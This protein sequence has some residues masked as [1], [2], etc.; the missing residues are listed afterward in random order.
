M[1][2]GGL[3]VAIRA[4]R[5][6]NTP[7]PQAHWGEAVQVST[8]RPMLLSQRSPSPPY[9]ETR[10]IDRHCGRS[11][12][13]G[14]VQDRQANLLPSR[15]FS[16]SSCKHTTPSWSRFFHIHLTIHIEFDHRRRSH[17]HWPHLVGVIWSRDIEIY[18]LIYVYIYIY[19][20]IPY[21]FNINKRGIDDGRDDRWGMAIF[22]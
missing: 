9:E 6:V 2:L 5:W 10:V 19:L 7:L 11:S 14:T 3:R 17:H 20:Y 21:G 1:Q 8:L 22:C 13:N 18:T 15:R 12:T 4:F 16:R